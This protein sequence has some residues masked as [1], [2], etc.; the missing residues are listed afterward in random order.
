MRY[1]FPVIISTLVG[2]TTA[3]HVGQRISF[4][5]T[6][7]VTV[8]VCLISIGFFS[9]VKIMIRIATPRKTSPSKKY[10]IPRFVDIMKTIAKKMR[11]AEAA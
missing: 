6:G 1:G 2:S 11:T 9:L 3:L 7:P 5:A 4:T 8:R 10:V